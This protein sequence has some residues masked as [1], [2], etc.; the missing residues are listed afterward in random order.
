[1]RILLTGKNGQVGFELQRSLAVLGEV[2]A[3]DQTDCDLTDPV[4]LRRLVAGLEPQIIVNPAAYTAVDRAESERDLAHAVNAVAPGILGEEASRLGA[5]VIHYSTDYVFDGAKSGWYSEDDSP[6]PQST[7]GT[8]KLAGERALLES[9]ADS[10]IFRTSWVFGAHGGNFAKTML[11][12]AG[13]RDELKVV[14]DQWGAPTS[15]ALLADVTAQVVARYQREARSDFPFGLY[16]LVAGGECSW[17][18]YARTVV[19]AALAAGKP[20]RTTPE[21]I[22]PIATADYPTAAKRPANSRMATAKL[23][24]TFGL[25]LPPWQIGLAHVLQQIF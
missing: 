15:A 20:L 4:S 17:H 10:L 25:V 21:R 7:Y 24:E 22:L 14:A 6:H 19:S 1:M 8:T 9:G 23:R 13:E 12:L 5:L 11:R 2:I 16:H 3:V 18:D